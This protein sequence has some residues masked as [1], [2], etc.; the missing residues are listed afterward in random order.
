MQF[1]AAYHFSVDFVNMTDPIDMRFQEVSSISS[2]LIGH[3][4]KEGTHTMHLASSVEHDN[5]ILKR[6]M[7]IGSE[8]SDIFHRAMDTL[9]FIP[10]TVMVTLLDNDSSPKAC[11]WFLEAC[12]KKWRMSDFNADAN[13]LVI[14]TLE[15]SYKKLQTV[16]V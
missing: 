14:E 15:F 10:Q 12:P 6:G 7:V 4:I 13:S 8:V 16:K 9:E 5:L 1:S 2:T 11:W 3:E